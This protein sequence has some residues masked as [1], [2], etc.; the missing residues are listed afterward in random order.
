MERCD[1]SRKKA[2]IVEVRWEYDMERENRHSVIRNAKSL[3]M[4]FEP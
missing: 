1:I 2:D 4:V 3:D